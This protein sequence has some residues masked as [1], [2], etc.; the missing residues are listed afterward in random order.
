[1]RDL[2][3]AVSMGDPAGIGPDIILKSAAARMPGDDTPWIVH[4]NPA[5]LRARAFRLGLEIEIVEVA[6]GTSGS[7]A[8]GN[9]LLVVPIDLAA[10]V[11]PGRPDPRNAAGVIG[12][13]ESAVAAVVNG[14]ARALVT[15]PIAKATLAEAGF[16][17]PGHT[18]FL[19]ELAGHHYA[20]LPPRPVMM[21]ADDALRVVPLTIHVP[22]AS[23]AP[24]V[25]RELIL[26]TI[27]ITARDLARRL[28]IARPRIAVAGLNPH[29]GE[30]GLLGREEIEIIRPAIEA[31]RLEGHD[32]LGPLSAD[33]M[34]HAAARARYDVAICMYHDQALIPL[35]TLAFD[36]GVNVTLGLP[37]VRTSPDHGTAFDIAGTGRASPASFGAAIRM[38]ARLSAALDDVD[39]NG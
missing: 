15:A 5:M 26:D 2:P 10:P 39:K 22:L 16:R 7:S 25:T 31:L 34:F 23:V 6:P 1:M 14:T 8:V 33:T 4:G 38:A 17:Y 11:E 3:I 20:M 27:R 18:E 19:A 13:I 35:K 9:T 37:F 36:S 24:L 12:A 28:R 32:I 30:D 21:L 29:A